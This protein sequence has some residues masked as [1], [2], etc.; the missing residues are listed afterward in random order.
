MHV[1]MAYREVPSKRIGIEYYS[2]IGTTNPQIVEEIA[3]V[4]AFTVL[5]AFAYISGLRGA[6]LTGCIKEYTSLANCYRAYSY[7]SA[8]Y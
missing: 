8:Q 4:V 6:A 3:L 7:S 5:A 2:E 1:F